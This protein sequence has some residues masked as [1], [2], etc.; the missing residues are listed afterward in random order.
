[1]ETPMDTKKDRKGRGPGIFITAGLAAVIIVSAGFY[2]K[3]WMEKQRE[4]QEYERLAELAKGTSQALGA[5]TGLKSGADEPEE[6]EAEEKGYASPIQFRE[7]MKVNPDTVGWLRIEGSNI[8]YPIVQGEDNDYYLSHDFYGQESV[9]G[10]IYLDYESQGDFTG[11]NQIIYGHHMKNG[12]MFRDVNYYKDEAYFKEHQYFSIYTP[13]RE[14]RLKAVACY[15]GEAA[16]V[17]RKTGFNSQESFDGFV[18]EM[19]S[20]CKFAEEIRY[21]VRTLYTFVT[22][23]YE[24]DDART[25]LFAVEVDEDGEERLPDEDFLESV[26]EMMRERAKAREKPVP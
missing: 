7:L 16:P 8:D 13:D 10:S 15:Y 24:I 18:K 14:I 6:T 3:G 23:S 26:D 25:F 4:V 22:C 21:P 5:E 11:R 17:V 12:S 20:P 9:S 19:V 1:M 2:L